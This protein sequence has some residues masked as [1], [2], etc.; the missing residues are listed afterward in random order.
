MLV[1]FAYCSSLFGGP[2]RTAFEWGSGSLNAAAFKKE[3]LKA[4]GFLFL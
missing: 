1:W 2:H 4:A 3:K